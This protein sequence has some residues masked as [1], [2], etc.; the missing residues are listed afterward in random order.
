[1]KRV[2]IMAALEGRLIKNLAGLD[3]ASFAT[4]RTV[5]D[6]ARYLAEVR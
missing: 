5:A 6:I 3:F 1:L 4:K 2:E